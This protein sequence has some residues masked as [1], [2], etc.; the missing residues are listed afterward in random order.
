MPTQDELNDRY[1]NRS[2][3]REERR[4]IRIRTQ[5]GTD[6][7]G[8]VYLEGTDFDRRVSN[9]LNDA[10]PFVSLSNVDLFQSGRRVGAYPFLC[11]AKQAIVYALEEESSDDQ[12][13]P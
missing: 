2:D 10:R 4:R 5:D 11:L 13:A 3:I 9:L 8:F 1:E 6:L 12:E 7:R